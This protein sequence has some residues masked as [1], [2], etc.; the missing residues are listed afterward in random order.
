[1]TNHTARK[2]AAV[3]GILAILTGSH[4]FAQTAPIMA[5]GEKTPGYHSGNQVHVHRGGNQSIHVGVGRSEVIDLPKDAGDIFIANPTVVNAVIKSARR[6]FLVGVNT[7]TTAIY[8]MDANGNR[9][10]NLDVTVTQDLTILRE[11]LRQTLPTAT[12]QPSVVGNMIVL[13]GQVDTPLDADRAVEMANAFLNGAQANATAAAG[14]TAMVGGPPQQQRSRVINSLTI[15]TKEQVM[16]RVTIAEVNRNVLKQ[17]GLKTDGRWMVGDTA[18]NWLSPPTGLFNT[19]TTNAASVA[20]QSRGLAADGAARNSRSV[21][22]NA[23]EQ[24]GL[25]RLLAEPTLVAQSG[26]AAKFK[27]GGEVPVP[28]PSTA[29]SG[30]G[31]AAPTVEFKDFGINLEFTPVVLGPG[32]ISLKVRTEVSDIDTSIGINIPVS[33]DGTTMMVPGFRSR[34]SETTVELPSGASLMTAGLI[35]QNSRTSLG[36][37][38]GVS[39]LPVIG[40]LARSRDYTRQESELMIT[41]T[42]YL[43]KSV[44]G[45]EIPRPDKGLREASDVAGVALGQINAVNATRRA[46]PSTDPLAGAGFIVK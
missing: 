44:N 28:Q 20:G 12:I 8:V 35:Q 18:L 27:V 45:T 14:G 21:T 36:G 29:A 17:L 31:T 30:G 24:N 33:T 6:L 22:F 3:A 5:Y 42:P 11:V 39:S 32:R 26:E 43:A 10:V 25:A 2:S 15:K 46:K 7:G 9:F 1:M 38:P 4:A 16:L 13:R 41:V 34:S 40:A 37:V 23:M 19:I